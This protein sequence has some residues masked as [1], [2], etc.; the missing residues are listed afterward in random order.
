VLEVIEGTFYLHSSSN[1]DAYLAEL[2]VSY[3]LRQLAL[4]A[5]PVITVGRS[6][7]D[8]T[9]VTNTTTTSSSRKT[10]D[11]RWTIVTDVG[12]RSH[13]V[14]FR[15][16]EEV[17]D[18]TLDGRAVTSRFTVGPGPAISE[19]QREEG[20]LGT[21]LDRTFHRDRMEVDMRVNGV[22]ASSVFLRS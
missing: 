18:T 22:T 15:A 5:S 4:L 3:I 16:G 12:L 21:A 19:V 10:S 7:K 8:S 17:A 9:T 20:G 2:G 14:T 1:F 6:C 11:C 13:S